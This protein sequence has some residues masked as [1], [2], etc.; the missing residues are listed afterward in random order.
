MADVHAFSGPA[1]YARDAC[2]R[3]APSLWRGLRLAPWI[4]MV[5]NA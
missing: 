5:T 1:E 4:G 2:G 3:W